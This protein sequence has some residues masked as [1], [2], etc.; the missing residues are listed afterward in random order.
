LNQAPAGDKIHLTTGI[1]PFRIPTTII[2]SPW[3]PSKHFAFES[4]T[5]E[6]GTR[7]LETN[8]PFLVQ[9]KRARL[10]A[11]A[12]RICE[13]LMNFFNVFLKQRLGRSQSLHF[14]ALM[15]GWIIDVP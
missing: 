10:T 7:E 5:I 3:D 2:D 8:F 11:S 15:L 9:I 14:M 13:D 4:L 12:T 1:R 6:S